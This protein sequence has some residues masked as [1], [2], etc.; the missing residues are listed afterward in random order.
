MRGAGVMETYRDGVVPTRIFQ[1]GAG[2]QPGFQE[3]RC[4]VQLRRMFLDH[5]Y[6]SVSARFN[7]QNPKQ[8][9]DLFLV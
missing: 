9:P 3:L 2:R 5:E 6:E 4:M 7:S 1:V 8:I